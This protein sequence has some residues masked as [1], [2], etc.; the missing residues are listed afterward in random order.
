MRRCASA[1]RARPSVLLEP[2]SSASPC[3]TGATRHRAARGGR[4]GRAVGFR[5]GAGV[6]AHQAARQ[7]RAGLRVHQALAAGAGDL[8][9]LLRVEPAVALFA[10]Q[11]HADQPA[12]APERHGPGAPPVA[13]GSSETHMVCGEVKARNLGQCGRARAV[14]RDRSTAARPAARAVRPRQDSAIRAPST[15]AIAREKASRRRR[16][17]RRVE[18]ASRSS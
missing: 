10:Q 2:L 8:D 3:A 1:S 11:Q 5:L 14:L 4:G 15:S 12:L 13:P 17:R 6:A 16:L 18:R 9:L 7:L